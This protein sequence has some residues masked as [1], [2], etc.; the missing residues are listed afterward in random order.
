MKIVRQD[1]R[2]GIRAFLFDA[3][4]RIFFGLSSLMVMEAILFGN[5]IM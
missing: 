1:S 5:N 3:L 2:D 4:P